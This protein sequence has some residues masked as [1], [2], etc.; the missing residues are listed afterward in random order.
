M[1]ALIF[2]LLGIVKI[3]GADIKARV[4]DG[5]LPKFPNPLASKL[6]SGQYN[7]STTR[8]LHYIFVESLNDPSKDPVLVW[9]SGGPGGSSTPHLGSG[10][11]PYNEGEDGNYE[12]NPYAWNN[13]SNMIFVDNPAGVG[14][15]YAARD[16]DYATNDDQF[17]RDAMSFITQFF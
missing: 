15:S 3:H 6:Y 9:F 14:Y 12:I 10:H 1:I 13:K 8:S 2:L 17:S 16:I 4:T 7:V 11:G 5:S